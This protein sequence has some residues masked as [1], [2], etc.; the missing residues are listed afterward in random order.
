MRDVYTNSVLYRRYTARL[1]TPREHVYSLAA[2]F[3]RAVWPPVRAMRL[4]HADIFCTGLI[5]SAHNRV[6]CCVAAEAFWAR[7]ALLRPLTQHKSGYSRVARPGCVGGSCLAALRPLPADARLRSECVAG[8]PAPPRSGP[9]LRSRWVGRH[10]LVAASP[11]PARPPPARLG[12][13]ISRMPPASNLRYPH[14]SLSPIHWCWPHADVLCDG[15][16]LRIASRRKPGIYGG[17]P[18]FSARKPP[19]RP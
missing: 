19:W 6:L 8:Q 2:F 14:L 10:G 15:L 13:P 18:R 17:G 4:S 3:P 5:A 1:P 16:T 12:C 11:L 9:V 7:S